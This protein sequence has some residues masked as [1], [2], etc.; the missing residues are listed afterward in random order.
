MVFPG[1]AG[2]KCAPGRRNGTSKGVAARKCITSSRL[3]NCGDDQSISMKLC[4]RAL[5]QHDNKTHAGKRKWHENYLKHSVK[6][7]IVRTHGVAVEI[8]DQKSASKHCLSQTKTSRRKKKFL[9][10]G[11]SEHGD[12]N[13][14]SFNGLKSEQSDISWWQTRPGNISRNLQGKQLGILFSRLLVCEGN[15]KKVR[16]IH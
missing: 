16:K 10:L 8:N 7:I 3:I 9:I 5:L 2:K 15:C 4:L 13:L 14:A 1:R 6:A 11:T 12:K